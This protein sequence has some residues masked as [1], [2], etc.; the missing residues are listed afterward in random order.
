MPGSDLSLQLRRAI[1]AHLRADEALHALVADRVYE[2]VPPVDA[3]ARPYVRY[4]VPICA[5]FDAVSIIGNETEIVL[6]VFDD[7]PGTDG[8]YSIMAAIVAAVD[9]A[10]IA[11]TDAALPIISWVGSTLAP[12]E[13]A[14]SFSHGVV[15]FKVVVTTGG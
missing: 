1:I 7:G 15:R 8:V 3:V 10:D 13:D 4:G 11:A 14:Q 5:P 12:D 6:H 9:D 2:A